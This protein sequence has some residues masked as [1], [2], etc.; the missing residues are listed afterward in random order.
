MRTLRAAKDDP[1]LALRLHQF[2]V[3]V[4][5]AIQMELVGISGGNNRPGKIGLHPIGINDFGLS[6]S[7]IQYCIG[8]ARNFLDDIRNADKR[9]NAAALKRNPTQF[10]LA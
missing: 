7:Q 9:R 6:P 1:D 5:I 3:V 8:R 10:S 4:K 2:E